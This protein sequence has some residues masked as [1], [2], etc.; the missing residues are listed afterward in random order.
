MLP[1]GLLINLALDLLHARAVAVRDRLRGETGEIVTWVVLAAGLA[2][3]AVAIVLA[4]GAK[5][6]A[7]AAGSS[8][9]SAL[10]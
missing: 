1:L 6:R 7:K 9:S 3:V 10:P 2:V 4:V 8:F 5:L